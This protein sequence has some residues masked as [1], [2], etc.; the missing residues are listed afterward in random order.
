MRENLIK[1]KQ[2]GGLAGHFGHCKTFGKLQ[3]YYFWP[4]M[5]SEVHKFVNNCNIYQHAK[6]KS[7]N[8]RLYAP[9]PIPKRPW[10]SIDMD[11]VLH[12]PKTQ[13]AYDS[14][15]V[16]VDI[17]SKMAHFIACFK[18]SDATHIANL[19]F[20]KVV[21]LHGLPTRIVLD[22]DSRFLGHFWRTLWKKMDTRLDYS[23]A[24]HPQRNGQNEVVNRSLGNLLRS[25][26]GDHHKQWDELLAQAKYA[27]NDSPK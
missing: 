19:F 5:M 2:S 21:K 25:L 22:K 26:V 9:F 24:C 6:G 23:L 12:L 27:Y 18:A 16:V 8:T 7:Q 10:D 13:K 14:V 20:R 15:F 3:H 4:R 11:F 17:F 1:E